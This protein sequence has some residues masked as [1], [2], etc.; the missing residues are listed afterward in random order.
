MGSWSVS[1][2]GSFDKISFPLLKIFRACD[3]SSFP[4]PRNNF[5]NRE[6]SILSSIKMSSS[7]GFL[8]IGLGTVFI[9]LSSSTTFKGS[10]SERFICSD[11]LFKP[12]VVIGG[13]LPTNKM[14][15]V[16]N[17]TMV[18][19]EFSFSSLNSL[20]NLKNKNVS[21]IL[22]TCVLLSS[23][24]VEK[25]EF[26]S[27]CV[28]IV[29]SKKTEIVQTPKGLKY[30][31]V[32]LSDLKSFQ[33]VLFFVE[34]ALNEN[35]E[36]GDAIFL[37]KSKIIHS[38]DGEYDSE[39]IQKCALVT[40]KIQI[41][42]RTPNFSICQFETQN[43]KQT[44]KNAVNKVENKLC[45]YHDIENL[46]KKRSSRMELSSPGF[47]RE[48]R[49]HPSMIPDK[50]PQIFVLNGER[51]VLGE[52]KKKIQTNYY[53]EK[54]Q[55]KKSINEHL[56]TSQSYGAKYLK[57]KKEIEVENKIQNLISKNEK[58]LFFLLKISVRGKL[59]P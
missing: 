13:L 31:T 12:V 4:S 36:P 14:D 17:G 49:C 56:E 38:F 24:E 46:K 18:S 41:F 59:E 44:C 32:L 26:I 52:K 5:L 28:G 11:M 53:E 25:K 3:F 20:R 51:I 45:Q 34:D 27:N 43:K 2:F 37:S 48:Q 29:T 54:K 23:I 55:K 7:F 22:E 35:L 50:N 15:V 47:L 16:L 42:G 19:L 10:N 30:S 1:K 21:K 39:F 9:T 40:K 57:K 58:F 33:I 6:V 8:V